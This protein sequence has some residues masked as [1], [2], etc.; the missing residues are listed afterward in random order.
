MATYGASTFGGPNDP[1]T[2]S[3]GY[4]G[5][6]LNKHPNS[7]AE[8][9]KNPGAQDFSAMG[10]LKYGTKVRVTNPATGKSLVLTKRDVGAGGGRVAGHT[11]G[12][13]LWY[14][15]AQRLGVSGTAKVKV[16]ILDG[17]HAGKSFHTSTGND[18]AQSLID[19]RNNP[20]R[21]AVL[22][23]YLQQRHDPTALL[24]L[25]TNL[26]AVDTAAKSA[27][28]R[29]LPAAKPKA[30]TTNTS[31]KGTAM[32]EGHRVAAWIKPEL[33]Y[34]RK[35]GWKGTINSGYRSY[36]DQTRIYNSGVRPAAR[37]GTSNHE[38]A[39]YPRGAVDVSDA[40][41]LSR[42]LR[43]KGS[44]LQWAGSKDPVHFSHPHGG[45]Y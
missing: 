37:P 38:G 9:S 4:K 18:T 26:K 13:D 24:Q 6:N 43:A 35:H 8:L 5:D 7:F 1:G 22:Q 14:K 36:A 28:P 30:L 32:F 10:H 45:S 17:K 39:D 19:Q 16:E 11:R 15:A 33:E 12:I 3:T 20:D 42:I 40:E 29:A 25:A 2:G 41:Q 27:A 31:A 23:Q 44:K 34:A 21:K